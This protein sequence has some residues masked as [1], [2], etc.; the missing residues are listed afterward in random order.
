MLAWNGKEIWLTVLAWILSLPLLLLAAYLTFVNWSV[1]LSNY[2]YRKPFVSAVTFGG[3]ICGA[4]GII[5]LPI[6]G[7]WMWCWIPCFLD[8]G[9]FPVIIVSLICALKRK[10]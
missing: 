2:V 8:W 3:G 9:S 5:L 10:K 1:F 7:A 4:I 6:Q